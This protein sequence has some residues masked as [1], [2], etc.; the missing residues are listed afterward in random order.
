MALINLPPELLELIIIHTLPEG[1]EAFSLTCKSIFSMCSPFITHH[2][3]LRKDF[4]VFRYSR[5][6]GGSRHD[7]WTA[8]DLLARIAAEPVIGRYIRDAEFKMD[9]TFLQKRERPDLE[10]DVEDVDYGGAVAQLLAE[11][12]YLRLAGLEWEEYWAQMK[13]ELTRTNIIEHGDETYS[14]HAAAFLLTFLPNV[15]KITL[16]YQWLSLQST[17]ALISAIVGRATQ[18]LLGPIEPSLARCVKIYGPAKRIGKMWICGLVGLPEEV[19]DSS[20]THAR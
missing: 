8:F 15:E 1:F 19:A 16:P 6:S 10:I 18:P 12:A 17:N 3:L 9:S 14:Q 13:A 2:N 5:E 7:I 20:P 4:S 11:S